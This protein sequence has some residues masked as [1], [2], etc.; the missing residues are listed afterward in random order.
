MEHCKG[1][2]ATVCPTSSRI[3]NPTH[4]NDHPV[5]ACADAEVQ[6]PR[7]VTT[8]YVGTKDPRVAMLP[9]GVRS[10]MVQVNTHFHLGTEHRSGGQYDLPPQTTST[11]L[12]GRHHADPQLGHYCQAQTSLSAAQL[13]PYAFQH[14]DP[15]TAVGQTYEN[16]YVWSTGGTSIGDGLAGAF[17]RT[18]NAAVLVEAQVYVIVNDPA[19]PVHSDMM[20]GMNKTLAT[21]A[22]KYLGSTTGTSYNNGPSCSPY[23]ITWH[24]DKTCHLVSAQ[25]FDAMCASM[26]SYGME[27]DLSPHSSRILVA[28]SLASTTALPL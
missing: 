26:Q 16:H 7:D 9:D 1:C 8:G 17:A 6:S 11:T 19:A 3:V 28:S 22:V 21:D 18:D 12:L 2:G 24:V 20:H 25:S 15:A 27:H 10:S 5:L 23:S 4:G 13:T 14:C